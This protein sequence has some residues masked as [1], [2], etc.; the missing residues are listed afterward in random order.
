[1]RVLRIDPKEASVKDYEL[2][3]SPHGKVDNRDIY[4]ALDCKLMQ[5]LYL[6]KHVILVID[7]EGLRKWNYHWSFNDRSQ[8]AIAGK[9]FLCG[10]EPNSNM[11]MPVPPKVTESEV[12]EQI[13]WLGTDQSFE[14]M[15]QAGRFERP[16]QQLF[17]GNDPPVTLWEWSPHERPTKV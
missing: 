4:K 10:Y 13:L 8:H 5:F 6:S 3:S 7:E 14:K 9:A 1:M 17:A 2:P 11:M 12:A 16:K 15:I